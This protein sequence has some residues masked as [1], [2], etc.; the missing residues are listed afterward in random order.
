MLTLDKILKKEE[1]P[2][3]GLV[4]S[5]RM[6]N[7]DAEMAWLAESPE[8]AEALALAAFPEAKIVSKVCRGNWHPFFELMSDGRVLG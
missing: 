7:P 6:L 1:V 3:T 2:A 4:Y 8:E 5:I